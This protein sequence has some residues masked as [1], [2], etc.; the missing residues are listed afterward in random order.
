MT[1]RA[2]STGVMPT[3]TG[4]VYIPCV[5]NGVW[6]VLKKGLNLL[7][8]RSE[9]MLWRDFLLP[10]PLPPSCFLQA[11]QKGVTKAVILCAT[12]NLI[13]LFNRHQV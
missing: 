10:P 3:T 4:D 8:T 6:W 1:K 12:I 2:I 5:V 9:Y 7:V 13:I 11:I